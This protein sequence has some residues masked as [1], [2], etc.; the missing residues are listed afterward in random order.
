MAGLARAIISN[1]STISSWQL[2]PVACS[3]LGHPRDLASIL[4][5]NTWSGTMMR[6]GAHTQATEHANYH[7]IT[8]LP[9]HSA[10]GK[11]LWCVHTSHTHRRVNPACKAQENSKGASTCLREL[12]HMHSSALLK[13]VKEEVPKRFLP[14]QGSFCAGVQTLTYYCWQLSTA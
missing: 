12:H 14:Q 7:G 2:Q 8:L 6:I 9:A 1:N 5:K 11:E 3:R 4:C 13:R 10:C